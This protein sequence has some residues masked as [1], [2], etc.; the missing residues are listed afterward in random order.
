MT[1][2]LDCGKPRP[3]ARQEP[4]PSSETNRTRAGFIGMSRGAIER[5][6]DFVGIARSAIL[7]GVEVGLTRA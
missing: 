4:K 7:I 1:G 6:V 5:I 2:D 3:G